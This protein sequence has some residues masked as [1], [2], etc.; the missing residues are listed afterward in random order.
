MQSVREYAEFLGG[1]ALNLGLEVY[2]EGVAPATALATRTE[3]FIALQGGQD[4]AIFWRAQTAASR[5]QRVADMY[6]AAEIMS[7][8]QNLSTRFAK[9]GA[10]TARGNERNGENP[11]TAQS[12]LK[13]RCPDQG[14]A[15]SSRTFHM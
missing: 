9:P 5:R 3:E 4:A 2:V 7:P 13:S 12:G 14:N 1:S 10:N 6:D 8:S 15:S 11:Q